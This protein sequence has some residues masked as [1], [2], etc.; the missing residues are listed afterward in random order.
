MHESHG[1][2]SIL[3]NRF[4]ILSLFKTTE[5]G[6]T[7]LALD[8]V[9]QKRVVVKCVKCTASNERNSKI[10]L[11]RLMVEA[12][13][14]QSLNHPSI[15][16]YVHSWGDR[17]DFYLVTE[18]VDTKNMK[19][20]FFHKPQK[21]A[22]VIEYILQLLEVTEYLHYKGVVHRDIKPSNILLSDNIVLIDFDASE[23]CYLNFD[24][25]NVVIGTP[26]YQCP[27]SFQGVISPQSDIF[28]IGGT[29]LFLLTGEN[30]S[31][32]LTRFRNLPVEQDL[33]EIAFKA[34]NPDPALRFRTVFEMKQK[35]LSL[36]SP[37]AKLVMGDV[38]CLLMKN[39]VLIGRSVDA[40]FKILDPSKFVSP[41]HAEVVFENKNFFISNKSIN[42]TF[43]YRRD[44]YRK[45]DKWALRD[46][47]VIVLC[48]KPQ[49]GPHKMVKFRQIS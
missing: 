11:E 42:G 18:Y 15:V 23:S 32:S 9:T 6:Q 24:H 37:Q 39:L 36:T 5:L 35:L 28:S 31:G 1:N 19:E 4:E 43:I 25:K 46:G 3:V 45:I 27:E 40:D 26:G 16:K 20:T 8:R 38:Q 48:Y 22:T 49:K 13:V 47:D 44:E 7:Y 34:L 10:K 21:R 17:F 29:I 41:I 2:G 33:L 14:L 30:P 12:K